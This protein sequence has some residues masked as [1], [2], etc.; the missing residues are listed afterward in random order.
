MD[1]QSVDIKEEEEEEDFWGVC[2][3]GE[4]EMSAALC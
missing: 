2:R 4:E 3:G 1:I